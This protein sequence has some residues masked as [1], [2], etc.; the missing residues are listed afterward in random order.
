MSYS[1]EETVYAVATLDPGVPNGQA[2]THRAKYKDDDKI[3]V[4][5]IKRMFRGSP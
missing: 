5:R 1:I 2:W 3:R 4:V